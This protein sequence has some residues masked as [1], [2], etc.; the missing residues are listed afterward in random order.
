MRV[1]VVGGTG[2]L[3]YHATLTLLARG[4]AVTCVA[5]K[6]P[7]AAMGLPASVAIRTLDSDQLD[8][9]GARRLCEGHQGVVFAAGLDD[10]T[11][12]PAPA[13][14]AFHR[15]N[16]E[17]AARLF[18]AAREVGARRGVLLGSYFTH[19]DRL[20]PELRLAD[21]HPYIRSRREQERACQ[22]AAGAALELA[23]LELPYIFGAMPGRRPLWAPL[24]AYLSRAPLVLYTAGGTNVVSVG[25]VGQAVA[26]ALE[27]PGAAGAHLVGDE[28]LTWPALIARLLRP[29]GKRRRVVTLP[30]PLVST[31]ARLVRLLHRMKG[32]QAGLDPV[33]FVKLQTRETFFDPSPARAALGFAG[34][35]LDQAFAA[36][37]AACVS[38]SAA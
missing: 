18:R 25:D 10:R 17:S 22:E 9:D 35:G 20:W 2:F 27:R 19:F 14:P 12:P 30:R 29:L 38:Q 23:I 13:Y 3:G 7:T 1:L 32:R 11:T 5:R 34:G 33:E 21:H 8:D 28:N 36:T 26:G 4:H 37:A 6:P 15:A 16:V 24:L 31:T